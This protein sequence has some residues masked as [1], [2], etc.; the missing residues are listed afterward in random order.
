MSTSNS[1]TIHSL[2]CDDSI[3]GLGIARSLSTA[4]CT[5]AALA[6]PDSVLS[7]SRWVDKVIPIGSLEDAKE[8]ISEF[9]RHVY[10]EYVVPFPGSDRMLLAL[11]E[12]APAHS[13][14]SFPDEPE[15][16]RAFASKVTQYELADEAGVRA[17]EWSHYKA[18]DTLSP[19]SS[20]PLVVRP[21][22]RLSLIHI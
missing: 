12:V 15:R 18:G 16:V 8:A 5:V 20:F 22:N 4:P 7:A 6:R 3:N 2:I 11:A 17:P 19:P 9:L 10:P 14:L 13:N 21:A 1:N